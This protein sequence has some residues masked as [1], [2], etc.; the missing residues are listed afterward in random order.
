M[1]TALRL[2]GERR[3]PHSYPETETP[4]TDR[5][6]DPCTGSPNACAGAN[7]LHSI[8]FAIAERFAGVIS[9]EITL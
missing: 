8:S 7:T 2:L 6:S 5:I 4:V 3:D 1:Q 9:P